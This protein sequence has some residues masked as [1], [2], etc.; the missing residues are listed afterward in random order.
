M[1]LLDL[2]LDS[3][4]YILLFCVDD[5]VSLKILV[6]VNSKL[7]AITSSYGRI[8]NIERELDCD[9]I[10]RCG[11]LKIF[12]WIRPHLVTYRNFRRKHEIYNYLW[13]EDTFAMAAKNGHK[14]LIHWMLINKCP[15]NEKASY[16]AALGGHLEILKMMK[17]LQIT[18][19]RN[20]CEA[21]ACKGHIEILEWIKNQLSRKRFRVEDII[22]AAAENGHLKILRWMKKVGRKIE[23]NNAL[24]SAVKGDQ[25]ES[26]KCLF[27]LGFYEDKE[28]DLISLAIANG[29]LEIIEWAKNNNFLLAPD[30]YRSAAYYNRLDIFKWLYKNGCPIDNDLAFYVISHVYN[31][32]LEIMKYLKEI[33][34]PRS[35]TDCFNKTMKELIKIDI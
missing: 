27:D 4:N 8:M 15:Y 18:I 12:E 6:F 3:L 14:Q 30:A 5:N 31:N 20:I 10:A 34:C 17:V 29:N 7:H 11:Y 13:N 28:V 24:L 21:A 33:N 16:E 9:D 32:K 19:S 23:S 1:N 2:P 35:N 26:L 22:C 25:L